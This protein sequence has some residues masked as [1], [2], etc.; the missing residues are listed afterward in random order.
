MKYKV[1]KSWPTGP[2]IWDMVEI[3]K[4]LD[5]WYDGDIISEKQ[6]EEYFVPIKSFEEWEEFK[7]MIN[8]SERSV[9][10]DLIERGYPK[11]IVEELG[12]KYVLTQ[13]E[14]IC[15]IKNWEMVLDRLAKDED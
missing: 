9:Y 12:L 13:T 8:G 1:I 6:V 3:T 2:D 7:F 15:K 5:F 11:G 14:V 10:D 4:K